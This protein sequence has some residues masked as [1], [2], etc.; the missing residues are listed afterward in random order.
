ML[1]FIEI[2]QAEQLGPIQVRKV[3]ELRELNVGLLDQY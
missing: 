2:I 1:K 3:K